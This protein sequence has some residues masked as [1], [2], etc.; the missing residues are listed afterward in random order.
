MTD[1]IQRHRRL[2]FVKQQLSMFGGVKRES[3]TRMMIL[4]PFHSE[5]TP[6]GSISLTDRF[7]GY[8]RCFGC[9]AKVGWNE[10][11][12]K[13]GLKPF[14]QGPPREE[15]TM[16][17]LMSKAL[18]RLTATDTVGYRQDRL[19]FGRLPP[20][21]KW[22]T[23]PTNLLIELGGRMC[24]K[25]LDDYDCWSKTK[26][27]YLPV[28]IK[29]KQRGYFRARL[30][31]DESGKGLPSYYLAPSAMGSNWSKDDGLWPYDHVL[32]MMEQMGTKTLVLVEGQRDA[33]RLILAGI[34]AMCI[35]G[36][37]SWSDVK[38]R[39]LEMAGVE[40]VVLM[41]D[42][43]CA[44]ISAT[45]KLDPGLRKFFD[46]RIIKLWAVKGSPWLRFK[47][48][49]EPSKAA[50]KAGVTLFDPGNCPVWILDRLKSKYF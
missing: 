41:M 3:G 19:K 32:D 30:K 49:A 11:A 14:Y 6:S 39:H 25:W 33:L 4:C 34:P 43:D 24:V 38:A 36:T 7:P 35:F 31:K 12:P 18:E 46:T 13:L 26:Y 5:N 16:S 37:Q 22:R 2:D 8:F 45:D 15:S 47:D 44:G 21:K 28:M 23:I 10:L 20:N 9:P 40:R 42:G 29:G 27:I 50:K 1:V 17:L 48:K